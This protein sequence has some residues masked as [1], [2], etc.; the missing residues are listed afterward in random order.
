MPSGSRSLM[1]QQA[2]RNPLNLPTR[3]VF[4]YTVPQPD[5]EKPDEEIDVIASLSGGA[6]LQ[7]MGFYL[8]TANEEKTAMRKSDSPSAMVFEL[9][10]ASLVE[11]NGARVAVGDGSLDKAWNDY[12]PQ[13]RRFAIEAYGDLSGMKETTVAGFLKSRRVKSG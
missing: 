1:P 10:K 3:D 2:S 11:V 13:G 5:P 9:A 7:S 6:S 4:E 8:L 12:G